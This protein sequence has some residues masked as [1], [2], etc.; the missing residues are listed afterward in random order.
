MVPS[1]PS[2]PGPAGLRAA[3]PLLERLRD[4]R[5]LVTVE[6]RPPRNDLG[7]AASIDTWIDTYHAIRGLAGK[8]TLV[9]LTDNAVGQEEEEN[10]HHLT[11]NLARD[12]DPAKLIPFL[13]CKH[14]LDYCLMYAARA[15]SSGYEAVT[16]LG[17]DTHVGPARCV[18]HA[19]ELR[20]RLRQRAPGLALGGWANPHRDPERQVEFLLDPGFAADFFLTQVV[21]H[22]DL[23]AVE[24]FLDALSRHRVPLPGVFGVFHYRS[25][26]PRTLRRL[27]KF[28]P[29]PVEQLSAEFAAGASADEVCARSIRALRQLGATRVY[30]S[31]L[32]LHGVRRRYERLLELV[33]G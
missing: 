10:L 1:S 2:R 7:R 18:E 27:A 24:R 8:D 25:A 11:T 17:G 16:V 20:Q 23:A 19:C 5:P 26:N 22:H 33:E 30:V 13:T 29:V 15:A 3:P 31:N 9:F 6:L 21:S 12:V 28:M 4:P 32:E 14:S